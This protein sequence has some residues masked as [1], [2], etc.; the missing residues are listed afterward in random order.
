MNGVH[1]PSCGFPFPS[2]AK[3]WPV[4]WKNY[5]RL[6]SI[7]FNPFGV[8]DRGRDI[9]PVESR[10]VSLVRFIDI[11]NWNF[12]LE[13]RIGI[14]STIFK[15]NQRKAREIKEGRVRDIFELAAK[16][17][18]NFP[19]EKVTRK[20]CAAVKCLFLRG[21]DLGNLPMLSFD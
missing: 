13:L 7:R 19:V 18:I 1:S 5:A 9:S 12:D 16:P 10:S 8:L 2:I 14:Q 17:M 11:S 21:N 4:P 20:Y 15:W 3:K 6:R